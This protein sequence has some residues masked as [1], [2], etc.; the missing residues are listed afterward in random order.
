MKIICENVHE[1]AQL[2]RSCEGGSCSGDGCP[3][4]SFCAC[5][6]QRCPDEIMDCIEDICEIK[7]TETNRG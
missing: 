1:F 2:V 4:W 6:G 5:G 7:H 3:F